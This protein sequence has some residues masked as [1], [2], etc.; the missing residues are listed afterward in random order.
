MEGTEKRSRG[1]QCVKKRSGAELKRGRQRNGTQSENRSSGR[2]AIKNEKGCRFDREPN[3][4]M[5]SPIGNE[6]GRV[7]PRSEDWCDEVGGSGCPP[8]T[9]AEG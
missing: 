5:M 9:S 6:E 7:S 4:L 1:T 3:A 2:Q 8:R